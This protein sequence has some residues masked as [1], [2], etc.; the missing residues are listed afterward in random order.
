MMALLPNIPSKRLAGSFV[1]PA[2]DCAKNMLSPQRLLARSLMETNPQNCV[3]QSWLQEIG[4]KMSP[5]KARWDDLESTPKTFAFVAGVAF[6]G[7]SD[8]L[9]YGLASDVKS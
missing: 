2:S 4:P 8:E 3:H 5:D 7:A 1:F 6:P 9:P